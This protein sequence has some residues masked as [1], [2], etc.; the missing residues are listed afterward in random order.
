MPW[1]CEV[2]EMAPRLNP[3]RKAGNS[4]FGGGLRRRF[5]SPTKIRRLGD[6]I[7]KHFTFSPDIEA[8]VKWM[9]AGLT[10]EHLA[11]LARDRFQPR[12]DMGVQV[13]FNPKVPGGRP[14]RHSQPR[15]MT[16][17]GHGIEMATELGYGSN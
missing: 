9:P 1:T 7:H 4:I 17:Q 12:L 3:Q 16:Q 14:H 13:D 15:E 5:C 11:A 8:S 10:R 6:I 2:A